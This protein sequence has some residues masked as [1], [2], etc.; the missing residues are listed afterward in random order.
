MNLNLNLVYKKDGYFT[1]R[2]TAGGG[3][4]HTPTRL[5][6]LEV[7]DGERKFPRHKTST[8][9]TLRH[10]QYTATFKETPH[11]LTFVSADDTLRGRQKRPP[12]LS[13][14]T[15]EPNQN[16]SHLKSFTHKSPATLLSEAVLRCLESNSTLS[17]NASEIWIDF[18]HSGNSRR[19][20]ATAVTSPRR[21][22]VQVTGSPG[23][24][25]SV[26]TWNETCSVG[27]FIVLYGDRNG[28]GGR[29]DCAPG[30]W[31]AAGEVY[32]K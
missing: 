2:S 10:D 22:W 16:D 20:P 4:D 30:A 12:R 1:A 7:E 32:S 9:R 3:D 5:S 31:R 11:Q 6:S 19:A 18:V 14:H 24:V 8:P 15:Q 23:L 13:T 27:N 21:C 29:R 25:M 26:L 17:L 28:E